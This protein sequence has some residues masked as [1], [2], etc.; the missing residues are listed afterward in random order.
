MYRMIWPKLFKN[1]LQLPKVSSLTLFLRHA[2][3]D[4]TDAD[5]IS[6]ASSLR[7]ES[8]NL[9]LSWTVE[10]K[11]LVAATFVPLAAIPHLK[12]FETD[13]WQV[14]SGLASKQTLPLLQ[15]LRVRRIKDLILCTDFCAGFRPSS[16][17][18]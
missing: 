2:N 11:T 14:I 9:Q 8:L 18:H 13:S 7:L 10:H 3:H 1:I 4:I 12:E 5:I 15:K 16:I 6:C 17:L